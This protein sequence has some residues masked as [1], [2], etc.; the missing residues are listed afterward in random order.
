MN[1]LVC[2]PST[3]QTSAAA[4]STRSNN[5]SRP[6][7]I[8]NSVLSQ[9]PGS[10]H[11]ID[12]LLGDV[13]GHHI[14]LSN[15]WFPIKLLPPPRPPAFLPVATM[16]AEALALRIATGPPTRTGKPWRIQHESTWIHYEFWMNDDLLMVK[17]SPR[18]WNCPW[19]Y[20]SGWVDEWMLGATSLDSVR[21]CQN[22]NSFD[23]CT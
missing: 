18:N 5:V 12:R 9:H 16:A 20:H 19:W 11:T 6:C 2:T 23:K 8:P 15:P 10:M 13:A 22:A 17:I 1:P 4:A 14:P 3:C 7:C 21:W